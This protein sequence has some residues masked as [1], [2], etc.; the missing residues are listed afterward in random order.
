MERICALLEGDHRIDGILLVG[1]MARSPDRWSDVDLEIVVGEQYHAGAVVDD[2]VSRM[3]GELPTLHH[4]EVA[5][6]DTLVRGFLLEDLL[7]VDL[8]FTPAGAF[9]VWG[10]PS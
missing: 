4:Y 1:S 3:Y 9:A 8:S 5:F 2:W 7:E 6:G 10:R